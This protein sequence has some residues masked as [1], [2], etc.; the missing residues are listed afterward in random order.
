LSNDSTLLILRCAGS[1]FLLLFLLTVCVVLWRDY[2][3]AA[4]QIEASRRTHGRL[5]Q[6]QDVGGRMV[7][8]QRTYSLLPLTSIGRSPTNTI[9]IDEPFASS[10]H[11]LIA[12]RDGTWWLE[13]RDS[14]NGTLLNDVPVRQPVIV[15]DGD[16]IGIGSLKFRIDLEF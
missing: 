4:A 2:R 11:A 1:A 10:E 14:R 3:G 13:D 7:A 12:L 16:M 8:M 6:L 15:T 9:P 5:V